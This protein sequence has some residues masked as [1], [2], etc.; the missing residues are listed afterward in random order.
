M[1][2]KKMVTESVTSHSNYQSQ[3]KELTSYPNSRVRKIL[4]LQ[5]GSLFEYR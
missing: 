1:I 3:T 2:L 4:K 5:K